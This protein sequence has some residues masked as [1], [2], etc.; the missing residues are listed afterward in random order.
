MLTESI[1]PRESIGARS[2]ARPSRRK[3]GPTVPGPKGLPL[4]GP[5]R[6]IRDD[7]LGFSVR[8]A[9]TYGEITG[10]N[11]GP[12]R[13]FMLNRPEYFHHVLV[14]NYRNYSKSR[15]Y[16]AVGPIF[17]NGLV[18]SDGETW[19]R[20]RQLAQP[21]FHRKRIAEMAAGMT[22]EIHGML[23][24]WDAAATDGRPIDT[25]A[26]CMEL[27]L[28]NITRAMFGTDVRSEFATIN[29]SIG[30]IL[31]RAEGQIWSAL[32]VPYWFPTKSNVSAWRAARRLND[33]VDRLIAECKE[34]AEERG[35]LLSMLIT[36]RYP[37]T[38][39]AMA[40]EQLRDEVRTILI[41]GHET[42]GSTAGFITYL[43]SKHPE[44]ERRL[45]EEIDTVLGG[46]RPTFD[47]LSGLKYTNMVVREALRLYPSAWTISR[48]ALQDDQI[49]PHHIPKGSTIMLSPYVM[50]R[51]PKYWDNPE[52]FIPER[53][54]PEEIERRPS[55]SYVPF[56]G[57]PR[58][59][60]G[61]NFALTELTLLTAMIY[62]RFTLQVVPGYQLRPEPMISLRPIGGVAMHIQQRASAF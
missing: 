31:R 11:L 44:I 5:I 55:H 60:I 53:F 4:I 57:G 58:G 49:G 40:H 19:K 45:V 12:H 41:A 18:T 8:M 32:P 30:T 29:R 3:N 22:E 43:I 20:Q 61:D 56:G 7:P 27:A 33:I 59:C 37:D 13:V 1:S 35:D 15:F 42:V 16:K 26:A 34:D 51:N 2:R 50:H 38:G 54:T 46:D 17:G 23:D 39:Q 6:E 47:H 25:L 52:A 24:Q 21:A 10:F 14:D 48:Q 28:G 62:Q 36:A 9:Q